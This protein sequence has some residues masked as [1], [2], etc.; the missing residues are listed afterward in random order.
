M[1]GERGRFEKEVK[2]AM[3]AMKDLKAAAPELVL[4]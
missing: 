4:E 3:D 1:G 2:E